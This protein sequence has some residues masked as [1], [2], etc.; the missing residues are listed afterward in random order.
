MDNEINMISFSGGRTSAMMTIELLKLPEYNE[1]NTVVCF[2]NTGKETGA[3]FV[4]GVQ[5]K[6]LLDKATKQLEIIYEDSDYEDCFCNI[7]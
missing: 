2:A 6:S 1:N 3:T 5:I 4:K 7:D